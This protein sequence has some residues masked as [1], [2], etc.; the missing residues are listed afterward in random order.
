MVHILF[1]FFLNILNVWCTNSWVKFVNVITLEYHSNNWIKKKYSHNSVNNDSRHKSCVFQAKIFFPL[2]FLTAKWL[3]SISGN[4]SFLVVSHSSTDEDLFLAFFDHI[5]QFLHKWVD[6]AANPLL[7]CVLKEDFLQPWHK[8]HF[9]FQHVVQD[10]KKGQS[11][12][13]PLQFHHNSKLWY[14]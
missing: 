10:P 9:Q 14:C 2:T 7:H 8:V 6:I 13:V 12:T 4:L 3:F 5:I 11:V 1:E